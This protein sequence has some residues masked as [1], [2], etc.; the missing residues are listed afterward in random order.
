MFKRHR[1]G[2]KLPAVLTADLRLKQRIAPQGAAEIPMFNDSVAP[3]GAWFVLTFL[4]AVETADY[5]RSSLRDLAARQASPIQ[6]IP[7]FAFS[8]N[9]QQLGCGH[10]TF[11]KGD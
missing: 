1:R 8:F 9:G 3:A 11:A 7:H 10:G 4:P 5:S 6:A 2:R